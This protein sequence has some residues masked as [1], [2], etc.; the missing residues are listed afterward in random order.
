MRNVTHQS[1]NITELKIKTVNIVWVTSNAI[2]SLRVDTKKTN[3][4]VY[5]VM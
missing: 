1:D 4:D 3:K 5:L 2:E